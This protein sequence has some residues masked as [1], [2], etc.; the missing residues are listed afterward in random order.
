[1]WTVLG[2]FA[3]LGALPVSAPGEE[4]CLEAL[5]SEVK[6]HETIEVVERDGRST[7]GK[8]LRTDPGAEQLW[9]SVYDSQ[10]SR[11]L[12]RAFERP[13][14]HAIRIHRVRV[15]LTVPILLGVGFGGIAFGLGTTFA[16]DS[17]VNATGSRAKALAI[18]TGIGFLTG[19]VTGYGVAYASRRV[20]DHAFSC[21][22]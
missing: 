22:P 11:F 1:V 21:G 6:T 19:F 18:M 20:E 10:K 12:D 4:T 3:L 5:V 14:I 13:A 9:L 17:D 16:E 15:N 8:F 2:S 7:K